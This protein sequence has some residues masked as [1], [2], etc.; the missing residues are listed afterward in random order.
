MTIFLQKQGVT[1][2][3]AEFEP[4]ECALFSRSGAPQ[5]S[6][7]SRIPPRSVDQVAANI[8]RTG[9]SAFDPSMVATVVGLPF[10][11]VNATTVRS[12]P[13]YGGLHQLSLKWITRLAEIFGTRYALPQPTKDALRHVAT[14]LCAQYG[15]DCALP[16]T[17]IDTHDQVVQLSWAYRSIEVYLTFD[18]IGRVHW[19]AVNDERGTSG[20]SE[21]PV[22][23]NNVLA[24]LRDYLG[25][26]LSG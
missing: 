9:V 15:R 14:A 8:R 3:W 2:L 19:F 26:V 7:T 1:P 11:L 25:P 24:P 21:E 4:I 12:E 10:R 17:E 6:R 22:D 16:L 13:V 5:S 20:A 23:A 18:G